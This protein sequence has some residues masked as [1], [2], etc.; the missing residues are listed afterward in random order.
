MKN[1]FLWTFA[2]IGVI[3]TIAWA[4][5]FIYIAVDPNEDTETEVES[6]YE[7]NDEE[8]YDE[9]ETDHKKKE[10]P[11]SAKKAY[12][13]SSKIY[14][15]MTTADVEKILGKPDKKTENEYGHIRYYY[16]N[17]DCNMLV[18]FNDNGVWVYDNTGGVF[19]N[20]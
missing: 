17:D 14:D 5:L 1:K 11:E 8:D 6:Y 20:W 7:S 12:F 16:G 18:E 4:A 15:D 9:E 13:L 2:V 19:D 10:F 3:S